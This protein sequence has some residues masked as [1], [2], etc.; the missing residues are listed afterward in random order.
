MEKE[1]FQ[2]K[3]LHWF[4]DKELL[5]NIRTAT[6]LALI[7]VLPIWYFAFAESLT[8]DALFDW[9]FGAIV[10]IITISVT[11]ATKESKTRAFDDV[12]VTNESLQELEETIDNQATKIKKKDPR[13]KRSI[14]F[15]AQYNKDKQESY[16]ELKTNKEIERLERLV[17]KYR[18]NGNEDKATYYERR[19][20]HLRKNPLFDKHFEPYD[21]RNIIMIQKSIGKLPKKKGNTEI[22]QNPKDLNWFVTF[23]S[24]VLRSGGVGLFGSIPIMFTESLS[25]IVLFYLSYLVV[26]AFTIISQYALTTWK[27]ENKYKNGLETIDLIQTQLLDFLNKK[28]PIG[29]YISLDKEKATD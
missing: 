13:S 5:R 18:L 16:N 3:L 4:T 27:M 19:I 9:K 11:L 24:M 21:L 23:V 26:L 1:N 25:D 22:N 7:L 6:V 29:E 8:L 28:C 14:K 12:M 20:E 2:D 10:I 15:M 17:L